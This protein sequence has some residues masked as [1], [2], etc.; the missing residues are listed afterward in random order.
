MQFVEASGYA[1]SVAALGDSE[2]VHAARRALLAWVE[3]YPD[4]GE[5]VARTRA[6]ILRSRSY[7]GYA[8]LRLIYRCDLKED[9]VYLYRL[10]PVDELRDA[11]LRNS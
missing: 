10:L 6:R 1:A 9:T 7:P 3:T 5:L 2:E 4:R 11:S 8:A